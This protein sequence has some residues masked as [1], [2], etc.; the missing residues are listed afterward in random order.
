MPSALH[1][2]VHHHHRHHHDMESEGHGMSTHA[3]SSKGYRIDINIPD[4]YY[5]ASAISFSRI[6]SHSN[7]GAVAAFAWND[8]Q[9]GGWNAGNQTNCDE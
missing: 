1:P 7:P 6:G 4:Y 8:R 3:E 9:V 2:T 5:S